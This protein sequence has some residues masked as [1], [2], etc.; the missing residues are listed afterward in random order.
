MLIKMYYLNCQ[1]LR[2]YLP[3]TVEQPAIRT[4][5]EAGICCC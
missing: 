3:E 5:M 4:K 1:H 2:D